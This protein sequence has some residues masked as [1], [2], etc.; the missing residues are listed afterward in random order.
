MKR[1]Q[2]KGVDHRPVMKGS[3]FYLCFLRRRLIPSDYDRCL[4]HCEE[5]K[6]ALADQ[7]YTTPISLWQTNILLPSGISPDSLYIHFAN[8]SFFYQHPTAFTA[9]STSPYVT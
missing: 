9:L 5:L 8:N 7:V 2:M 4:T 6:D 1:I 3:F